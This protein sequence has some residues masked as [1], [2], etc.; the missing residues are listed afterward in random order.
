MWEKY[1]LKNS[2]KN[3]NCNNKMEVTCKEVVA[4]VHNYNQPPVYDFG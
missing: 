3:V 2:F 1:Q 4:H